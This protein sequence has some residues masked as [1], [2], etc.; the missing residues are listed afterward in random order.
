[1]NRR[2]FLRTAGVMGFATAAGP[3]VSVA[4]AQTRTLKI[5]YIGAQSGMRANFGETT[6][7]A[8]ER[9]RSVVKGGLKNGGKTYPVELV[10]KDNQSDPNRSSV[11]ASELILREKCDLIL[12]FDADAAAAAGELADTRGVPTI[13][14]DFPWTGWKFSR[15][16][17]QDDLAEK[18]FPYT[19]PL[20]LGRDRGREELPAHVEQGQHQQGGGDVLHRHA[21]RARVRQPQGR[22]RRRDGAERVQGD[23]G[24]LLQ[25]RDRRLH[26]SGDRVQECRRPD[27]LRA[28]PAHPLG[29]LLEPGGAGRLPARGLHGHRGLPVRQRRHRAGAA[30]RRDVDRGVV[31]AEV[32]VQVLAHRQDGA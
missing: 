16:A 5:G 21:D 32:P 17:T 8:I 3:L 11:T 28:R 29:D 25:V 4:R 19:Y 1:M 30:R 20:L 23:R 27:R 31:D 14:T 15:G 13:S 24:R 9:I 22:P 12:C 7:W 2:T 6:P 18:S 26:Q 10:I